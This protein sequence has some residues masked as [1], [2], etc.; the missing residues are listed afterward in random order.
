MNF[1]ICIKEETKRE[2]MKNNFR[3]S[4][5][6]ATIKINKNKEKKSYTKAEKMSNTKFKLNKT[7]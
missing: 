6:E 5:E 7:K 2:R 3:E 4:K 1:N